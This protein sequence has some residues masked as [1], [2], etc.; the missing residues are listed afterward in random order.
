MLPVER[1]NEALRLLRLK[2]GGFAQPGHLLLQC[3]TTLIKGFIRAFG[4]GQRALQS[5]QGLS[6]LRH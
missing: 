5:L 4:A 1:M 2:R 3:A 6:F